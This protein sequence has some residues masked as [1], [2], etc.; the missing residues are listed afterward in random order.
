MSSKACYCQLHGYTNI[1]E[2]NALYT[3]LYHRK[4]HW[5]RIPAL[6]RHLPSFDWILYLDADILVTNASVRVEDLL[7]RALSIHTHSMSAWENLT[8]VGVPFL[9]VQDGM[10]VNSGGLLVRGRGDARARRLLARWW[11]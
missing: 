8:N 2:P 10:E 6:L 4:P 1:I 11:D 7:D 3:K 5:D 9:V